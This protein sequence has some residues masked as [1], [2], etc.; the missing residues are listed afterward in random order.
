MS[1]RLR[2]RVPAVL[3]VVAVAEFML[4]LD[5]SIVN[6]A[7]PALG[8]ELSLGAG[9]LEWAVT[10]YALTF[11]GFL[12]LGGRA[13]DVFGARRVF[14]A[15]LGGFTVASLACGLAGD[16]L[17]LIAGRLAQGTCAGLLSPAT[18]SLLTSTYRAP[19]ERNHALSVWTAVAIGGGAVGALVGGALTDVVSWRA[20][21]FVNVP[22]AGGVILAA[23]SCLPA[24]PAARRRGTLDVRGAVASTGAVCA[25]V[26]AL[27][28]APVAGWGWPEVPAELS[29]AVVLGGVFVAVERS[30]T[31]PLLP[32]AVF[33]SRLLR[34]GNLLSFL[35]FVPVLPTWFLLT[36]YLQDERHL[37]ALEAGLVF[38]P[39]S[40]AV[41]VG[42]QVGFWL[43]GHRDTRLPLLAGGLAAAGGL[44]WLG[45]SSGHTALAAV[46]APTALSMMGGGLMLAPITAAA[47]T[48]VPAR[49]GGLAS[50]LL[51]TTR[52]LGGAVGLAVLGGLATA[53]A[54][55]AAGGPAG[56][57]PGGLGPG[58]GVALSAGAAI[59]LL[60]GVAGAALMPARLGEGDRQESSSRRREH[61]HPPQKGE[62]HE[63]LHPA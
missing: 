2:T 17:S 43:I 32:S 39:L 54:P 47:T 36:L 40:A 38:A 49:L 26:C 33:R 61:L 13:A 19:A 15:A 23:R 16:G 1:D 12:L 55:A 14:L 22:I 8:H 34:L 51:N 62:S 18:L 4:V 50:G 5:V 10:G 45:R 21:F 6:V 56:T 9:T 37:T 11:G 25:L 30:A 20:I 41:I 27:S 60:T 59:A 52:Q 42:S 46:I 48:G 3:G 7:L 35:S 24:P 53:G 44:A 58:F 63:R 28:R 31:A 29:L 57:G